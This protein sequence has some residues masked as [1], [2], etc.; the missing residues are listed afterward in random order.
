MKN[1]Q[2]VVRIHHQKKGKVQEAPVCPYCG[3]RSVLRPA[4]YVYGD[5][6]I[7][8]GSMLYVC[9]GYPAC[10]AYVGVHEGTKK[11]KGTLA[12]SELRN[13]RI[14]A[15]RAMNSLI[16]NGCMC[17]NGV[18]AWLSCSLNLPLKE[19]HIGYFLDYMCEQTIME[20]KRVLENWKGKRAA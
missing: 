5:N 4:E 17:K 20:C 8:Q 15:H 10:N 6:T 11:P 1:K 16:D 13:M 14:C 7:T 9:S 2:K 3:C 19:T 18:Y 12:D